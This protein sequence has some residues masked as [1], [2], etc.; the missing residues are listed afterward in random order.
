MT[1]KRGKIYD[2]MMKHMKA[3]NHAKIGP[4]VVMK[5]KP[6]HGDPQGQVLSYG[7]AAIGKGKFTKCSETVQ[8]QLDAD[9]AMILSD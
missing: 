4:K 8:D 9:I 2:D 3:E 6:G 7:T 5:R 1:E